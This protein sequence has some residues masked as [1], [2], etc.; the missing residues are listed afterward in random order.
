VDALT[1]LEE[2][3]NIAHSWA[4]DIYNCKKPWVPCLYRTEKLE[5]LRE[6]RLMFNFA[7]KRT[8]NLRHPLVCIDVI[9]EGVVFGL[10][11]GL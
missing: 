11:V 1:A 3:I 7:L 9:E 8:P 2:M 5:P 4:L 10:E 6:A